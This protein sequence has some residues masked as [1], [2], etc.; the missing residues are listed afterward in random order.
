MN[1]VEIF[2]LCTGTLSIALLIKQNIWTWPIGIAYTLASLYVFFTAKLYAD[3]TLH[4]FFLI[5][6]AYGWYYWLRGKNSYDSEL[7]VSR[8]SKKVLAYS[9]VICFF[10][11]NFSGNLFSTYTDA[12]LPY[13]DNTTSILSILAIWLQSRKKIESWI[14]WLIIDMLSVGIYFYKELYFYSL[15]YSV[16]IAMAFLGYVTW[17]KSYSNDQKIV[18]IT[19]PESCGK[20]TLARQ[21]AGRWDAPLVNEA[22]R[23]YLQRKDSYQ[24][25]D[26]LEIAK[27]QSAMEQEK[28][29]ISA[30]KLVCDT[31]LLVILIWSEVKYGRCDPWIRETLEN[32]FN[33]KSLTRHYILCDPKIPWQQDRLRENP[34]NRDELFAVYEK[35]L[36][37]YK[38][39]YS[40]VRGGPQERFQQALDCFKY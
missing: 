19:G 24:E 2:G 14:L 29:V 34:Y 35:K 32:C 3:F 15:L 12:D 18:V 20:T 10:A 27:L 16:Y 8:E 1:I 6:S 5:M 31:D 22:A 11:V 26:L 21:L 17:L 40:I 7:P 28:T 25:S 23:D 33:K 37:D 38:L 39:A 30:E 9:I 13:L 36:Q 4:I